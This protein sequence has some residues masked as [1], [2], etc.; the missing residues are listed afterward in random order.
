M[1]IL[2]EYVEILKQVIQTIIPKTKVNSRKS[3]TRCLRL[4]LL[5]T[6]FMNLIYVLRKEHRKHYLPATDN[7]RNP[8]KI[9]L[10]ILSL[11]ILL[12]KK[13]HSTKPTYMRHV[14]TD[15]HRII[16]TEGPFFFLK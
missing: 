14:S 12:V 16:V 9:K 6:R 2:C 7:S 15:V 13:E 11:F 3:P 1:Y 10:Q 8:T 5:L 4:C